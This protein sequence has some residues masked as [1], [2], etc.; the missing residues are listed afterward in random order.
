MHP[1]RL[2]GIVAVLSLLL[3]AGAL[4]RHQVG[5]LST[6]SA[7]TPLL[8]DLAR[9]CHGGEAAT[10]DGPAGPTLPET[11][12]PFCTAP[13]PLASTPAL[14][15]ERLAFAPVPITPAAVNLA[16]E[17][18]SALRPWVRGPPSRGLPA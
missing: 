15:G 8:Q 7:L 16:P 6:A 13:G 14:A 4:V 9:I 10:P 1:P 17:D 18:A 11:F 12:C 5:M 2:I 3:N